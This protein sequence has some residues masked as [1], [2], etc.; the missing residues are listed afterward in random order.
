MGR[1][2]RENAVEAVLK[3]EESRKNSFTEGHRREAAVELAALLQR[4]A[5]SCL[6]S[7]DELEGIELEYAMR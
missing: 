3:V 1:Q 4:R 7:G 5:A 6:N 2:R